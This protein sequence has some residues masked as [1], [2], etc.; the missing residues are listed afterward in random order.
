MLNLSWLQ[1][2]RQRNMPKTCSASDTEMKVSGTT[3][4]HLPVDEAHT[5]VLFGVWEELVRVS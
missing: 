2:S 5:S 3:T 4:V 1:S